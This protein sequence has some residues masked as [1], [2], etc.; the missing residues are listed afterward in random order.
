M[1]KLE[2]LYVCSVSTDLLVKLLLYWHDF[3][4]NDTENFKHQ[5]R[6]SEPVQRAPQ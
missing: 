6:G 4:R 3:L 1:E 5:E 2:K